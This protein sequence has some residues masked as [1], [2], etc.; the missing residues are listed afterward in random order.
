MQPVGKLLLSDE[1]LF[2]SKSNN[3]TGPENH[4]CEAFFSI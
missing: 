2:L 4:S 3:S 1:N